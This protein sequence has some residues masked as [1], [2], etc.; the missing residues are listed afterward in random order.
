MRF[1]ADGPSIPDDLLTARDAGDV[2]FFCG[3]GVS[4]HKG[5]LPDFLRLG[6]DVMTDLGAGRESL[7]AKLYQRITEMEPIDGVGGL[8][9][10]DRIFSL[11]EREFE[12][13]EIHASVAKAIKPAAEVDLSAHQILL[14]LSR[15][16]DKTVRLV[17]TNFDGLFEACDPTL[18]SFAPPSLPDPRRKHFGGIIHLHGRVN[19]DYSGAT[20]EDF[21]VSSADF[22][23]AYLSD[24]WA[25]R[26]IQSLLARFQIVFVG[27]TADDPPVQYLL[28]A[29]NLRGGDRRRLFAFQPGE[30]A[31]SAALWEHRGVTAIPFDNRKSFASLWDTLEAWADRARDV[32]G[33]YDRLLATAAVGPDK[34]DPHVRGQIAHILST[35]EGARRVAQAATPLP[36]SWLLVLD[37]AMRYGRP[38]LIDPYDESSGKIDPYDRL[39]L[40]FDKPSEPENP[41]TVRYKDREIPPGAWDAFAP[42]RHDQDEAGEITLGA[43]RGGTAPLSAKLDGRLAHLAH[44]IQRIASE[45]ISLWWAAKRGPF[46]PSVIWSIKA[47]MRQEP[48]RWPED[49]RRG[50]WMLFAAWSDHREEPD[51]A[52]YTLTA[53][54]QI[55]GWSP[56]RVRDYVAIFR[57]RITVAQF[58]LFEHPLFWNESHRPNPVLRYDIDYPLPHT[59]LE[60]PEEHLEYAVSLFRAN[61]DLACSLHG[62]LSPDTPIYMTTTRP[63]DGSHPISLDSY[64]VTGS[65]VRF[66]SLMER[67]VRTQP[68]AARTEIAGW[69]RKDGG[70]YARLRIWA[71]TSQITSAD[72]AFRILL[73]FPN[74]VFWSHTH[75]RDLLFAIRDRWPHLSAEQR[76]V[77]EQHLLTTT[78]PWNESSAGNAERLAAHLRLDRLHW[79]DGQ[80]VRFSFDLDAVT[81]ALSKIA[82]DWKPRS[83]QVAAESDAPVVR[84]VQLDTS[85]APLVNRS[86]RE[87]LGRARD[88]DRQDVLASISRYPF[89]GLA[90]QKPSRALG[91]L[92]DAARLGQVPAD[93]WATF[94]RVEPRKA[95]RVRMASAIG[96]RLARLPVEG[97]RLIAYPVA[98]WLLGLGDRLYGDLAGILPAVWGAELAALGLRGENRARAANSSWAND[99]LNAPVGVLFNVLLKDPATN[100]LAVGG[101][102]PPHWTARLEQLLALPGDMRRHALVM[103]GH[104]TNWLY[105]IDPTWTQANLLPAA[106]DDG[107]DGDAFWDG[108]IW[109]AHAPPQRLFELLKPAFLARAEAPARRRSETNI[110]AG[111]LLLGWMGN[112]SD[113]QPQRLIA[114]A[115]FRAILVKSDEDLRSQVLWTLQRWAAD[116]ANPW[117]T[118]LILF[119]TDVWPNHRA[120]RTP[121]ISAHLADLAFAVGDIFPDVV[122][123]I[124]RR[125]VPVRGSLLRIPPLGE[126]KEEH[127]VWRFAAQALDLFW[128]VLAED[129]ALWPY[130]VEDA[131]DLLAAVRE[132]SADPRLS[133]LRRRRGL[134]G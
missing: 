84:S 27:Y 20:D 2:I 41:A 38:G 35:R 15:S 88:V 25:T 113:G 107:S 64:G 26:F 28:E 85:P 89:K 90:E 115:E 36:A 98:E 81:Q 106:N 126:R 102:Y 58:S 34:L 99:A 92:T 5:K 71:A 103:A 74:S 82:P 24:G 48:A 116:P 45:P 97:L 33:W 111:F 17:T 96:G 1:Y 22:G 21:I 54:V 75:Q 114:D 123:V 65:I 23:R 127:L 13:D 95:D 122:R 19:A 9:A 29:L 7:A 104:Q 63:D 124:L 10:T 56:S 93:A 83:A 69:P 119:L 53:Q 78:C 80:G 134:S 57:P 30:S 43:V 94:L 125:L 49:I 67:L 46:H 120:I 118:H 51:V 55:E 61:L 66:Q 70:I 76:T 77:L 60:I 31:D 117:R 11:L 42:T 18:K 40:D 129:R 47:W 121:R 12:K 44:W 112:A 6:R 32:D 73:G 91:A 62:E 109:N 8:V 16:R 3:A 37:P 128:A 4:L 50:W 101:G 131:L 132:T 105:T 130:G 59:E 87:I 100:N 52:V 72:E 110:V 108:L 133:E 39:A 86:L 68:D 14:D 79:L